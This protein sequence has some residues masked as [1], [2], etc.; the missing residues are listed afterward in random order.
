[1]A[2][3]RE[4]KGALGLGEKH[5]NKPESSMGLENVETEEN[6][7]PEENSIYPGLQQ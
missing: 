4:H 1:M 2:G 3:E 6:L 5:A 7:E